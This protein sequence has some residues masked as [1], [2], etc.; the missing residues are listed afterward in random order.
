MRL[1][2]AQPGEREAVADLDALHSLDPHHRARQPRV[3]PILLARVAAEPRRDAARP[4]LDAAAERVLILA[5]CVDGRGI[6]A[7]LG[8]RLARDVDPDLVEERLRHRACRDVDRGMPRRRPLERVADVRQPVLLHAGEIRMARPRQRDRLRPLAL[9]LP[10][11]RPGAH[12]PRPVLVVAIADYERERRAERAAVTQPRE[13]LD[14]VRLDL[15]ARRAAVALLAAAEIGVDRG[16]VEDEP[17]GQAGDDRDERGAVRLAG[18]CQVQ[19]HG[20][21]P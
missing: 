8:Q 15:L 12:P 5:R 11:R 10:L 14:L 2:A 20:G 21:E 19:R 4:H 7:G 16:T 3:E 13:H 18:R 6:R 9:G 17:G 1:R